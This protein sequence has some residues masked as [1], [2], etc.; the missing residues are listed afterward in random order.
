MLRGIRR[1]A[2]QKLYVVLMT[3]QERVALQSGVKK[4]QGTGQKVRRAQIL[5]KADADGPNWIDERIA[6]AYAC[7]TR[8]VE[9]LRQRC[10]E[11]GCD[12]ALNRVERQQPPV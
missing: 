3:K 9:R 5:L 10:V 6:E 12:E 4:L 2:M 7:R 11:H 8:T 1:C